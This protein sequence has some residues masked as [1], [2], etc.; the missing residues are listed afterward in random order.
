MKKSLTVFCLSLILAGNAQAISV[1]EGADFPGSI[2]FAASAYTVGSLEIGMN[3]ISGYLSGECV[4]DTYNCNMSLGTDSQDSFLLEV[5]NGALI[6]SLFVTTSNV[7]GP[8]GFTSSFNLRD[9]STD[10]ISESLFANVTS[11]NLVDTFLGPGIYGL[12]MIG[13]HA[14]DSGPYSLDWSIEVNMSVVPIPAA[15]WLFATGLL[16]LFGFSRYR[17]K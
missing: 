17:K 9:A 1:T 5:G 12:S 13:Q 8:T 11:D 15:L 16:A 6:D 10:H 2:S 14:D 3:T 4:A 7:V